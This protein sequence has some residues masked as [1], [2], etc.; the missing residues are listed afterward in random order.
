MSLRRRRWIF[1]KSKA[2]NIEEFKN[3][4]SYLQ[5]FAVGLGLSPFSW[6]VFDVLLKSRT[7][8]SSKVHGQKSISFH[9]RDV[10]YLEDTN[11]CNT[12]CLS[13]PS[14]GAPFLGRYVSW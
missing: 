1:F 9:N 8:L 2:V 6:L 14:G 4:N 11:F 3:K 12:R 10:L 7:G 5:V 13:Y